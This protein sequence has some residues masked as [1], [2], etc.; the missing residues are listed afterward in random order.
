MLTRQIGGCAYQRCDYAVRRR[1]DSEDLL[2]SGA[3][4]TLTTS[5]L[6]SPPFPTP[7]PPVLDLHKFA[8]VGL[9]TLASLAGGDIPG[10]SN[11]CHPLVTVLCI[12]SPQLQRLLVLVG[13]VHYE[14]MLH[15]EEDT[16]TC[17]YQ[18]VHKPHTLPVI[19]L[20][21]CCLCSR[22]LDAFLVVPGMLFYLGVSSAQSK[23]FCV[24]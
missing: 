19:V 13:E 6:S 7:L 5:T 12:L 18:D 11:C 3:A 9:F 24:M 10:M 16:G 23:A 14:V 15:Q 1:W 21:A 4:K 17:S 20:S 2:F 22:G 8:W